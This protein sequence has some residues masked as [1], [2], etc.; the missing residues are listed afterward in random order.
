MKLKK[1]LCFLAAALALCLTVPANAADSQGDSD[2]DT[3]ITAECYLP[4]IEINVIV[5]PNSQLYLNP[6]SLP[7]ELDGTVE[8]SQIVCTTSYIE[9]Q[10]VVPL[11]VDVS[12]TGTVKTGS[13]MTLSTSSTQDSTSTKKRAFFYFEMMAVD[14]D[15]EDAN[16]ADAYDA[17]Q[18]L[19]VRTT[20]KTK[21]KM[22]TLS[23]AGDPGCFG[24]FHLAGDCV[25]TPKVPWT[26]EDGVDVVIAFSFK[27][28]T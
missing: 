15:D 17:D 24:A 6:L 26:E 25:A 23:K 28:T 18:H 21:K 2:G 14:S 19:V 10:S 4:D 20:S 13:D 7:V 11:T 3:V 12:V 22:I 1:P 16:W 5:P 27:A 9:N 8:D